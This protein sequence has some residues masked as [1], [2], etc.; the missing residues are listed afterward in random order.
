MHNRDSTALVHLDTMT[1]R[2]AARDLFTRERERERKRERE[3][4]AH[5][6]EKGNG[7]EVEK[8]VQQVQGLR[9]D[10][11]DRS[12]LPKG[13]LPPQCKEQHYPKSFSR[14]SMRSS[15]LRPRNRCKSKSRN[16]KSKEENFAGILTG[17]CS[18]GIS[19]T[20]TSWGFFDSTLSQTPLSYIYR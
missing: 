11:G 16:Q 9:S 5:A 7:F 14:S 10:N 17:L 12:L 4:R 6:A 18:A 15:S 3:T 8:R 1:K 20:E 2:Y 19:I 13:Q